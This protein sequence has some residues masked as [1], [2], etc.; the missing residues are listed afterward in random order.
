MFYT[1]P[2]LKPLFMA[3]ARQPLVGPHG[4]QEMDLLRARAKPVGIFAPEYNQ[5]EIETLQLDVDAGQLL[6]LDVKRILSHSGLLYAWP[7]VEADRAARTYTQFMSG[8]YSRHD[9]SP[10]IVKKFNALREDTK[11]AGDNLEQP[12]LNKTH[13]TL[14]TMG[15]RATRIL[16]TALEENLSLR[17]KLMSR[18]PYVNAQEFLAGHRHA[19][20]ARQ[21]DT[22]HSS[23]PTTLK[24]RFEEKVEQGLI[25]CKRFE[26]EINADMV[27]F[28][29]TGQEKNMDDMAYILSHPHQDQNPIDNNTRGL[30]HLSM[31]QILGYSDQ[32]I[33]YFQ[34][35]VSFSN[36]QCFMLDHTHQLRRNIRIGLMKEMGPQWNRNP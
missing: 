17:R 4:D 20:I 15:L 32:D 14:Y 18:L 7:N 1:R 10:S 36:L 25:Q 21:Y 34:G 24:D 8:L 35:R 13:H 33:K 26:Y 9:I 11:I 31:G 28:G 12:P 27:I 22:H 19:Y 5:K 3:I 30:T 6:R 2:L 23:I 29:Q 16:P